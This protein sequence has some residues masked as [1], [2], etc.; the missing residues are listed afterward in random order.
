MQI[1]IEEIGSSHGNKTI[2]MTAKTNWRG[3]ELVFS[4]L[5]AFDIFHRF[6]ENGIQKKSCSLVRAN[7]IV[8]DFWLE[9]TDGIQI[10][11]IFDKVSQENG[12]NRDQ[13]NVELVILYKQAEFEMHSRL[14]EILR[15]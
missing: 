10:K 2:Q 1:Y 8:G 4:T 7:D 13:V 14:L 15:D 6:D 3:Q 5:E 9:R 12:L 11:S